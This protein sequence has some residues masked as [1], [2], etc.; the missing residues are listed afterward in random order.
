MIPDALE[1]VK[2]TVMILFA[3][4]LDFDAVQYLCDYP[5]CDQNRE[6]LIEFTRMFQ[7]TLLEE[8][9]VVWCTDPVEEV[10]RVFKNCRET[11]KRSDSV[12]GG[13]V[14]EQGCSCDE[15]MTVEDFCSLARSKGDYYES[16]LLGISLQDF[17]EG[18]FQ[19]FDF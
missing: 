5:K 4:I 15:H 18:K 14:E 12:T 11:E 19:E 9:G 8:T 7:K 10:I 3:R 16:R 13:L 1:Y 17:K 2:S 6:S